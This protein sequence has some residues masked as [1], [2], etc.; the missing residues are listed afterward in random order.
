MHNWILYHNQWKSKNAKN[1]A[2]SH[3]AQHRRYI[4]RLQSSSVHF[5]QMCKTQGSYRSSIVKFA[6]FFRQF[7]PTCRNRDN[8]WP[9]DQAA[10]VPR[11]PAPAAALWLARGCR[12]WSRQSKRRR[13]LRR[14]GA[15]STW[16]ARCWLLCASR[17]R[18]AA[19]HAAL[20][21]HTSYNR[22]GSRC[23]A[24]S[25]QLWFIPRL[26]DEAGSTSW[27]DE[28]AIWSFEWC[29]IANIHEAARRALDEPA[30]SCK[31]GIT[32][33]EFITGWPL[34]RHSEIPGHFPDNVRHSCPC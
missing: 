33:N 9:W 19:V 6:D 10:G 20:E 12:R 16:P 26:H 17:S 7:S 34:S 18:T 15:A 25:R 3:L 4:A 2:W 22:Y 24:Y 13:R 21:S 27:L 1:V 11:S 32:D 29:N 5:I 30:S 8:R 28:L 14:H 23:L 31:R